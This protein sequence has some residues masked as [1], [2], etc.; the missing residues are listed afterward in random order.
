[1]KKI[2]EQKCF[3]GVQG[4]Y[5]H[6]SEICGC[7]MNFGVFTPP[8][9]KDGPVPVLTYL[10]GLTCTPDNFIVKAGAQRVAAELGLMLVAPD[11]SPRGD[12]VA[13]AAD[14]YDMGK[15]AGFY[16]DATEEPWARHYRMYSYI[17]RELPD[18]VAA[19]FPADMI[20]QGIFG[21]SMGGHGALTIHLK[22][23]GT[24]RSVSAFAPIV[25]PSQVPWGQKAF[26]KYLGDHREAWEAYDATALLLLAVEQSG[27]RGGAALAT[28]LREVSQTGDA[29][30]PTQLGAAVSA[31]AGG[32]DVD[33]DGASGPVDFDQY[34]DVVADYDV[35]V[36]NSSD[37]AF[38]V[39]RRVPYDEIVQ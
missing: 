22:H 37:D 17:A 8:Q 27:G 6:E 1:M 15:G 26:H 9:A 31:V 12:D 38:A 30:G 25:A 3:G 28:A 5:E 14:E 16:L 7:T 21:H 34:G 4:V 24:Y 39:S 19:E 36:F 13:D 29:Y 32:A 11:T 2:S 20:R 23:P 18:L 10:A 35:W 33:F